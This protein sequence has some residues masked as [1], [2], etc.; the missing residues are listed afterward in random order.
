MP[1]FAILITKFDEVYDKQF[2]PV[3]I[4]VYWNVLKDFKYDEVEKAI[5]RCLANPQGR[6]LPRPAD[7]IAA[8]DTNPQKQALKAWDKAISAVRVHGAYESVAFD[9]ALIHAVIESIGGWKEFCHS[10]KDRLAFTSKDFQDRYR[11]YMVAKPS[12]HPKYFTGTLRGKI[13]LIGSSEKAMQVIE[14]GT[15]LLTAN[16]KQLLDAPN[17]PEVST[18]QPE[19][20]SAFIESDKDKNETQSTAET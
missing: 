1:R 18:K 6:F 19:P 15:P 16:S 12:R 10:P 3:L 4:D 11:D 9:D 13:V 5:D 7:I 14:T 20:A 8:M 2:T 17:A